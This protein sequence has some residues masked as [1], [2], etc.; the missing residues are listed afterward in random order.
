MS[1]MTESLNESARVF[2][3]SRV[4]RHSPNTVSWYTLMSFP[5]AYARVL[6][7]REKTK[8]CKLAALLQIVAMTLHW[9]SSDDSEVGT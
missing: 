3:S 8:S 7:S 1:V 2:D 6:P 4:G 9:H 5:I